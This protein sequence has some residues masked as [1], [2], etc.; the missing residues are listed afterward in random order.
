MQGLTFDSLS[1]ALLGTTNDQLFSVDPLTGIAT[2][3][4]AAGQLA[5]DGFERVQAL[6][7]DPNNS[8]APIPAALPLFFSAIAGLGFLGRRRKKAA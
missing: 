8:V 5:S 4:G 1:N 2:P 3:I 7:F 6:A